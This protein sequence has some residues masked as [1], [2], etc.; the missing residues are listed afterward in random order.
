MDVPPVQDVQFSV[1]GPGLVGPDGH[2]VLDVVPGRRSVRDAADR[3]LQR[4]HLGRA[5]RQFSLQ[6]VDVQVIEPLQL[7]CRHTRTP[8]LATPSP[9]CSHAGGNVCYNPN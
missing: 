6:L 5:G 2:V 7:T 8:E 4:C 3:G 9:F 1:H